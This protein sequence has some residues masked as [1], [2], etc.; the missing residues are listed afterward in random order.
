[1]V[2]T[3]GR[4]TFHEWF[5]STTKDML[6]LTHIMLLGEV[7]CPCLHPL[8]PTDQPCIWKKTLEGFGRVQMSSLW[9]SST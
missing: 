5:V 8:N 7:W 4:F 9:F 1:M 3:S 2:N 6:F